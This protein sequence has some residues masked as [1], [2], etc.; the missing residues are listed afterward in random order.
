MGLI[1]SSLAAQSAKDFYDVPCRVSRSQQKIEGQLVGKTILGL[2]KNPSL[3]GSLRI[4]RCHYLAP[5]AFE[6]SSALCASNH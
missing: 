5:L 3:R 4:R 1:A 2:S 6:D